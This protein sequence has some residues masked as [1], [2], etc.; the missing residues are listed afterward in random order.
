[1]EIIDALCHVNI[2]PFRFLIWHIIPRDME[3]TMTFREA[4]YGIT[5]RSVMGK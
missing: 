4:S 3:K 5:I 1:M 2:Q